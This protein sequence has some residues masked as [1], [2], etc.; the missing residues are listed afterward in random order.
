[1][2]YINFD[3]KII[4]ERFEK[5]RNHMFDC[6]NILMYA[7]LCIRN[8]EVYF[9]HIILCKVF[10]AS[11]FAMMSIYSSRDANRMSLYM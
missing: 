6:R 5:E 11:I 7:F 9:Y 8:S 1:M 2:K 3:Q 10:K 4:L